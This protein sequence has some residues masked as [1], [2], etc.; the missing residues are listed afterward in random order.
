MNP[1]GR[2]LRGCRQAGKR[3]SLEQDRPIAWTDRGSFLFRKEKRG[4]CQKEHKE[5]T[6]MR[7]GI[8]ERKRKVDPEKKPGLSARIQRGGVHITKVRERGERPK[9]KRAHG[10]RAPTFV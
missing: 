3:S 1:G 10:K 8:E 4:R 6:Q 2:G 7:P 9:G 5:A